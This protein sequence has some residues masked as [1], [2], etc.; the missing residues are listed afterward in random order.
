MGS[1]GR[2]HAGRGKAAKALFCLASDRF[3]GHLRSACLTLFAH[4]L[5]DGTTITFVGST[6]GLNIISS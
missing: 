5:K 6:T 2:P 3:A 1:P 4:P